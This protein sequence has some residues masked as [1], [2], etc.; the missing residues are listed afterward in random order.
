MML[1][2]RKNNGSCTHYGLSEY[3]VSDLYELDGNS[4]EN[5]MKENAPIFS[6]I[7]TAY[8]VADYLGECLDSVVRQTIEHYKYELII[9]D[10]GSTDHSSRIIDSYGIRY[11]DVMVIHQKNQ[12]LSGARN[13][14]LKCAKG[15]YILFL[16][17]D[18]YLH[19]DTLNMLIQ[20]INI[21]QPE[22]IATYRNYVVELDKSIYVEPNI[23]NKSE[24][25]L[26]TE[27]GLDYLN[28]SMKLNVYQACAQY[29]VYQKNFLEKEEAKFE[30]GVFHEDEL[31]TLQLLPQAKR[32]AVNETPFYYH[33]M[34]EGSITHQKNF[35]KNAR[36]LLHICQEM[37]QLFP[38]TINYVWIRDHIATLY[39]NATYLGGVSTLKGVQV[40]RKFP[41]MNAYTTKNRIKAIIY[42][43]SPCIY[44]KLDTFIKN[45][46]G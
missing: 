45:K 9:I 19:P 23:K 6:I 29:Y 39:M 11:N 35:D 15:E 3:I 8:N 43:I 12:G 18:D 30:N 44:I 25:I 38:R 36:D 42:F 33:R 40:D 2:N 16:D 46:I 17:G 14:G 31:W 7:V 10:D 20:F 32:V 27:S 37:D 24:A 26:K 34:R 5:K 13:V 28:Q 22:I 1:M 41:L 21:Y 4:S